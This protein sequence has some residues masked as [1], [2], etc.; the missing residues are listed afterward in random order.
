[1]TAL[2]IG[3]RLTFCEG[4]LGSAEAAGAKDSLPLLLTNALSLI[5]LI[6]FSHAPQIHTLSQSLSSNQAGLEQVERQLEV[7]LL[8]GSGAGGPPGVLDRTPVA[9][10][11]HEARS[12][13]R[14]VVQ[15]AVRCIRLLLVGLRGR[16]RGR[17]GRREGGRE[18]GV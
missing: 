1:M 2:F 12:M 17:E 18:C 4:C 16:E 13:L 6:P 15:T 10:Y 11:L 5:F 8:E 9:P 7:R 14:S 3:L